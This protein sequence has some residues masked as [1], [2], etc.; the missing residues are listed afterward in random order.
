LLPY[1]HFFSAALLIDYSAVNMGEGD[2][3]GSIVHCT[4]LHQVWQLAC[5]LHNAAASIVLASTLII[6]CF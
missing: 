4:S 2:A 5:A 1:D 3:S 6:V